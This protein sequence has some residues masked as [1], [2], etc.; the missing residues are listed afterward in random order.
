[1]NL[2]RE[3]NSIRQKEVTNRRRTNRKNNEL[4]EIINELEANIKELSKYNE[5]TKQN[6][7]RQ[8][9][10]ISKIYSRNTKQMTL[11]VQRK[12]III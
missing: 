11:Y 7:L 1:M 4:I 5:E 6:Q 10:I 9:Q 8:W 3:N 12:R 2:V